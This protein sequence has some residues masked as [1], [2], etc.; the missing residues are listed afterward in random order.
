MINHAFSLFNVASEILLP[1]LEMELPPVVKEFADRVY[2][3]FLL[4]RWLRSITATVYLT[5]SQGLQLVDHTCD[6]KLTQFT[7]SFK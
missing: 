3:P 4:C 2:A 1:V 5:P 6:D 7:S